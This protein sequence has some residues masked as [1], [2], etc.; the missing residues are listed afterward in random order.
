MQTGLNARCALFLYARGRVRGHAWRDDVGAARDGLVWA[1]FGIRR[2][3]LFMHKN[4]YFTLV[5]LYSEVS[6]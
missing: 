6:F 5:F 2:G 1:K 4:L 3:L